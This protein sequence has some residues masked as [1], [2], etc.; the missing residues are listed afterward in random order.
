MQL[1]AVYIKDNNT[2]YLYIAAF[3][4]YDYYKESKMKAFRI[5][6]TAFSIKYANCT[7]ERS[8]SWGLPDLVAE[9]IK[10]LPD[11]VTVTE[12]KFSVIA[13]KTINV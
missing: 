11:D 6:S 9:L 12:T 5:K 7:V 4:N 8:N 3:S 1:D 13:K 10:P 2:Q